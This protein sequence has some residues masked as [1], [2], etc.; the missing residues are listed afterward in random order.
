MDSD[1]ELSKEEIVDLLQRCWM[2]H[3]GAW[4]YHCMQEFGIQEANRINKAAIKLL[5]PFE[6]ARMKK[7]LGLEKEI[8]TCEELKHF[9]NR[10]AKLFIPAFMNVQFNFPEGNTLHWEFTPQNCF[11]YKGIKRIGAIDQY[12]CGVIY[13]MGCWFDTLGLNYAVEPQIEKCLM[14]REGNCSGVFR[15]YF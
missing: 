3:D 6:I 15:F 7:A 14:L 9:F 11:A 4:F 2:T 13:R 10:A 1:I 12:E 5:A 8:G